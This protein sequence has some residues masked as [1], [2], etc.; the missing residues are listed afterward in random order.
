MEP[1]YLAPDTGP[2]KHLSGHMSD[3]S[4][5]EWAWRR[6]WGTQDLQDEDDDD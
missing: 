4:P 5:E 1:G 6:K 3:L 2:E